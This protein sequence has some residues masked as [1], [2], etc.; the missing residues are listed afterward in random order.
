MLFGVDLRASSKRPSA[1]VAMDSQAQFTFLRNFSDDTELFQMG[2]DYQP[3]LIAIGAPL[4]LP[5]GLCCLETS[6]PCLTIPPQKKGRQAELEL[7]RMGISCFFTNKRSIIRNLIYRGIELNRQL[8]D[9]GYQVIEVYPHASKTILFGD[10]A[11][12]KNS[13]GSISFM[14]EH[15]SSLVNGLEPH[16]SGL[17]RNG[18]D[19]V[20]N[21]YTALLHAQDSTDMLGSPDEGM[22][23]LPGLPH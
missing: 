16:L 14:R 13:A 23:V 20:L 9:L 3:S 6:C 4:S 11:P 10:K 5:T 7:A 2:E 1:V 12:P 8:S 22:L 19:A 17:D 15:L 21:A 18:C